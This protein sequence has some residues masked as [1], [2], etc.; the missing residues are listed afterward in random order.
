[1]SAYAKRPRLGASAPYQPAEVSGMP[2][3]RRSFLASS[4]AAASA[5]V[6]S[7]GGR[8]C[9]TD[10]Q[11]VLRAAE[12]REIKYIDIHTHLGA[13][14]HDRELTAERLVRFMDA[15]GVERACVLPLVSPEAAPIPQ[16]VGTALAAYKAFPERIIPFCAVDPRAVSR[17]GRRDGHV[18]GVKGLI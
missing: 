1:P 9:G 16:P 15:H 2:F 13:F 5:G 11:S 10:W 18:V 3:S 8:W 12:A 6:C 17:P 4:V 7:A 14:Y